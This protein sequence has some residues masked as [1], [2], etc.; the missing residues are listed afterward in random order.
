MP[1][2]INSLKQLQKQLLQYRE[3]LPD[4]TIDLLENVIENC[5]EEEKKNCRLLEQAQG[6]SNETNAAT[7]QDG[8]GE[9]LEKSLNEIF[10]FDQ[11]TYHFIHVNYGARTNLGYTLDE[12][13]K[14]TPLDIKPELTLK[15][16]AKMVAPLLREEVEILK[17][18]TVHRRKDGS[19]Y[20]VEVHLQTANCDGKKV[21]AA[22]ILDM[23][24]QKKAEEEIIRAHEELQ[25]VSLIQKVAI[26]RNGRTLRELKFAHSELTEAYEEAKKA[27]RTKS[28]FLANMSHEIRTPLTA[29]LGFTDF[30]KTEGDLTL[31]PK[32]RIESIDTIERNGNYLLELINDILDISKIESGQFKTEIIECSPSAIVEDV[33][34]LL[35]FRAIDK[36]ISFNARIDGL[37]PET[38]LTDPTRLRQILIN[39]A[40][41]AIKFTETGSVDIVI[42][43]LNE[44]DKEAKILFDVIDTGIGLK[45]DQT[46]KI[47]QSFS[48]A[49]TSVTRKYGGTG[50]GLSI[51]KRL[52]EFLGGNISVSSVL[53]EGSTFSFTVTTG[54]VKNVKFI[55]SDS[56]EISREKNK[57]NELNEETDNPLQGFRVLIAEDGLDNQLLFGFILKKAGIKVTI[58]E[59][60]K[61]AVELANSALWEG[62]PYDVILMDMQMPVMDGYTAT[63]ILRNEGYNGPIIALTAHAMAGDKKKCLD[64]GCDEFLTKPVDRKLLIETI[65]NYV[66]QNKVDSTNIPS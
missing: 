47:F 58:A 18:S 64:A 8:F 7:R 59:D 52:T 50:L 19:D 39:L 60:G 21:F 45:E 44:R 41:N 10:I 29:I 57:K 4:E 27:T 17:F 9:I 65:T 31:A 61:A 28:D 33:V 54:C 23:T 37:I 34:S 46:K 48:Q 24:E 16:F 35:K 25:K 63:Q 66:I 11:K 42:R 38:I 49:D 6:I 51:S 20:P 12:L 40:G 15:D 43:L 36:G 30:L 5:A 32:R 56:E 62:H 22:I 26:E 1:A 14:M 3:T 53:G 2:I 55:G 13:Q